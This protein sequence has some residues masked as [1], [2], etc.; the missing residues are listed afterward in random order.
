M[1]LE[2][3]FVLGIFGFFLGLGRLVYAMSVEG[4]RPRLLFHRSDT[5]R[6]QRMLESGAIAIQQPID[7]FALAREVM[8]PIETVI[9]DAEA[10]AERQWKIE[11]EGP[12]SVPVAGPII[13]QTA[14]RGPQ[15]WP[16]IWRG[17]EPRREEVVPVLQNN[18]M[19]NIYHF[20]D[21]QWSYT[22]SNQMGFSPG[23]LLSTR[24]CG[25]IGPTATVPDAAQAGAILLAWRH[26]QQT[27]GEIIPVQG[28]AEYLKQTEIAQRKVAE[29]L[30]GTHSINEM[31]TA[32]PLI[33]VPN[34]DFDTPSDIPSC[35]VRR[36]TF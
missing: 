28:T 12:S 21:G 17:T 19:I 22:D 11:C 27:K 5:N 4:Y 36:T 18:G 2:I 29:M 35:E 25:T 3:L 34:I 32:M 30:A 31:R 9:A 6:T 26:R 15:N 14:A 8:G 13:W 16:A 24:D 20:V 10:E 7:W 33:T 1:G 23:P